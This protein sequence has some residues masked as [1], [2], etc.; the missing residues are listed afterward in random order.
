MHS[1]IRKEAIIIIYERIKKL[2]DEKGISIMAL[3]RDSQLANG[4]IGG[5]RESVPK[6]DSLYRVARQLGV[7]IDELVDNA[8]QK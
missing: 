3:E 5:W 2:C 7:S 4:T 1:K 6:V 8:L